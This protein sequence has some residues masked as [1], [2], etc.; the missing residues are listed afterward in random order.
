MTLHLVLHR[1]VTSQTIGC[2]Y[3]Q[4]WD[5]PFVNGSAAIDFQHASITKHEAL[6][7]QLQ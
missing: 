7:E 1:L 2:K 3:C 4:H 5:K 6:A